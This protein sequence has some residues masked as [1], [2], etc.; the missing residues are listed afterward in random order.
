VDRWTYANF[1]RLGLLSSRTDD[2]QHAVRPFDRRRDGFAVGEGAGMIVLEELGHA[3]SRGAEIWAEV[4]GYA[5]TSDASGLVTPRADGSA[6][7]AAITGALSDAAMEPGD[8]DYVNAYGSATPTGDRTELRALEAAFP[9]AHR[10]PLVS[11][12]KG[13]IGHLLAASG[14]VEFAATALALRHQIV[15]PTL[16]LTDPTWVQ[17]A[18][19]NTRWAL[20]RCQ[21]CI[22]TA[23]GT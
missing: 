14:A 16:N 10:R 4:V 17:V 9:A 11:G 8:L 18:R 13:A 19:L 22:T 20:A 1:H 3:R 5:A 21:W 23:S 12:I 7:A 6:L 15:P 2:P